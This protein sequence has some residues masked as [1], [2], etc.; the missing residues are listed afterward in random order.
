LNTT[1]QLLFNRNADNLLGENKHAVCE[2]NGRGVLLVANRGNLEAN[3]EV[4]VGK[5]LRTKFGKK[6]LKV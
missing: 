4:N 2:G 6:Y 1:L 3:A 5:I